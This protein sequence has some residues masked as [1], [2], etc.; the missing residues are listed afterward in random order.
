MLMRLGEG[1]RANLQVVDDAETEVGQS[2][3]HL[4]FHRTQQSCDSHCRGDDGRDIQVDAVDLI[5]SE[6]ED[7][8]TQ[9]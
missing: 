5:C 1:D 7:A 3:L 8:R 9:S 6:R 2:S 4:L